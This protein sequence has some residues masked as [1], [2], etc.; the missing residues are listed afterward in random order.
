MVEARGLS[1]LEECILRARAGGGTVCRFSVSD[2]L[3]LSSCLE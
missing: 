3:P 1:E 2:V